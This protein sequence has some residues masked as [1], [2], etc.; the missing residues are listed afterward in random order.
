VGL[1]LDGD[2]LI[3]DRVLQGER[4][5][6][7]VNFSNAE[8]DVSSWGGDTLLRSSSRVDS[9]VLDPGEAVVLDASM[10]QT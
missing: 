6:V 3:F 8:C 2:V 9:N 1:Q 10:R 5:R 7:M 4:I